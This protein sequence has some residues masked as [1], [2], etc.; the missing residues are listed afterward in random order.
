MS[1]TQYA[2]T[3][4]RENL[5]L[6]VKQ[7][8]SNPQKISEAV[9]RKWQDPD[10]RQKVLEAMHTS[11]YQQKRITAWQVRLFA[12]RCCLRKPPTVGVLLSWHSQPPGD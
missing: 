4:L 8:A 9:K 1:C 6:V 3:H 11:E 12:L 10:Y 2:H 7:K 5:S